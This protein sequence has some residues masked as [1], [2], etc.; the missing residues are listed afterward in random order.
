MD[1]QLRRILAVIDPTRN[2]QWALAKAVSIA[3]GQGGVDVVAYACVYSHLETL[4]PD[5]L[6]EAVLLRHQLW[7]DRLIDD[8]DTH[9]VT[10]TPRVAWDRDWREAIHR[11]AEEVEA[12]LVIKTASGR[13]GAIGGSDRRLL[14]TVK[15]DVLLVSREPRARTQRVL[16]ALN[17]SARDDHHKS[18]DETVVEAGRR[19]S[20]S[21]EGIELHVVSAYPDSMHY[22]HPN[23]LAKRVGVSQRFA[24]TLEGPPAKVIAETARDIDSDIVII[25][26]VARQG[27]AGLTIGN[28]AEKVLST[29]T[30]DV[31]VVTEYP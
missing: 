24:H 1:K 17:P 13:S 11:V 18:L 30:S 5:A 31:L 2:D 7:L 20:E 12:S 14:R 15:G 25:G 19:I 23:D 10:V 26:T 21:Q 29:L 6:R 9:G 27:V 16:L 3:A 8:M 4:D 22:V 28:T